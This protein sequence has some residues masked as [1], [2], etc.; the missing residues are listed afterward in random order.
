MGFIMPDFL[1]WEGLNMP[2]SKKKFMTCYRT[3]LLMSLYIE[4]DPI[5]TKQKRQ[6]FEAHLRNCR[7]CDK[8]Y[9]EAVW[10]SALLKYCR[11]FYFQKDKD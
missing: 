6:A 10:L 7:K 3:Q 11:P 2:N 1:S 8:E 5:V 4:N 9:W